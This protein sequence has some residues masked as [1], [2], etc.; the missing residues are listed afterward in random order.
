MGAF[1]L[2][3]VAY[4]SAECC[5]ASETTVLEPRLEEV[6][7][8]LIVTGMV[9]ACIIL[10]LIFDSNEKLTSTVP[11]SCLLL[12]SGLLIGCFS[13]ISGQVCRPGC[14]FTNPDRF[15]QQAKKIDMRGVHLR[16]EAERA[17]P[18][19]VLHGGVVVERWIGVCTAMVFATRFESPGLRKI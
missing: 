9:I 15:L 11:E 7:R 1:F 17:L 6:N 3:L 8:Y 2:L 10:K 5:S 4:L 16:L 14:E 12:L 18:S 13:Y 19:K